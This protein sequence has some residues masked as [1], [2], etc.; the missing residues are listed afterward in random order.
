[1][2]PAI[3]EI[4]TPDGVLI[5]SMLSLAAEYLGN[6]SELLV[7]PEMIISSPGRPEGFAGKWRITQDSQQLRRED[8][9]ETEK[10][11]T[12]AVRI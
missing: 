9:W 5:V 1:M 6:G 11:V 4:N 2:D 12:S 7:L 8:D 10:F 3:V